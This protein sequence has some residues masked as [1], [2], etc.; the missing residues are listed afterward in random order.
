MNRN[1]RSMQRNGETSL[2]AWLVPLTCYFLSPF[3][4]FG[5]YLVC[6]CDFIPVS[7][8]LPLLFPSHTFLWICLA[9]VCKPRESPEG[10]DGCLLLVTSTASQCPSPRLSPAA[11][12]SPT[13]RRALPARSG[14]APAAGCPG[15]AG[16]CGRLS[17]GIV[18]SFLGDSFAVN[19]SLARKGLEDWMVKQKYSG[20]SGSSSGG[21]SSGLQG[22]QHRAACGLSSGRVCQLPSCAPSFLLSETGETKSSFSISLSPSRG[23]VVQT[24]GLLCHSAA[25]GAASWVV[26]ICP[27]M[28]LGAAEQTWCWYKS[29]G[30]E[31]DLTASV[32]AARLEQNPSQVGM[33]RESLEGTQRPV[34]ASWCTPTGAQVCRVL[35]EQFRKG[36]VPYEFMVIYLLCVVGVGH[37]SHVLAVTT[38]WSFSILS[39][40]SSSLM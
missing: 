13:F 34:C 26:S 28:K 35:A 33:N 7:N 38:R 37:T 30:V 2:E 36:E 39:L 5:L 14:S 23:P 9:A 25:P 21:S 16:L 20:G 17:G 19:A 22:C 3:P 31:G 10:R 24:Q 12:L 29:R 6:C 8:D 32:W 4:L 1:C 18:S 11:A 40:S 27:L 15:P